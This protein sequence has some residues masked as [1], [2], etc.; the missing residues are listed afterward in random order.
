MEMIHAGDRRWEIPLRDRE[1]NLPV[2]IL[3]SRLSRPVIDGMLRLSG[4]RLVYADPSAAVFLATP[5]ADALNL[6]RVEPTP[7]LNPP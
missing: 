7:L 3:D 6:P 5:Q 2:V 4:W 1:G